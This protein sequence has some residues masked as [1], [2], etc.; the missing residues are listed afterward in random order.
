MKGNQAILEKSPIPH[1]IPIAGNVQDK[2]GLS[3]DCVK[4]TQN[5]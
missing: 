4:K 2:P 3:Q 5:I 1:L